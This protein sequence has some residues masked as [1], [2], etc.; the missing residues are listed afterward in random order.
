MALEEERGGIEKVRQGRGKGEANL[1][2]GCHTDLW[3]KI[4]IK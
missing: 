4:V 2:G 3:D 1:W